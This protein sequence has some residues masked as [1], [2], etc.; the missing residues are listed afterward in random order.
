MCQEQQQQL[1]RK[2]A[3]SV[4]LVVMGGQLCALTGCVCSGSGCAVV[5]CNESRPICLREGGPYGV[6]ALLV[7]PSRVSARSTDDQH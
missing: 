2:A 1:P 7:A 6:A 3:A 4:A 5:R